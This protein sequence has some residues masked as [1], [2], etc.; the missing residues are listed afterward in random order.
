MYIA[1][2]LSVEFVYFHHTIMVRAA[3]QTRHYRLYIRGGVSAQPLS[4]RILDTIYKCFKPHMLHTLT[5]YIAGF[6]VLSSHTDCYHHSY[7]YYHSCLHTPLL[8]LA[9]L[10]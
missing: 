8:L 7:Y 5:N 4:R 2:H 6:G 3:R 10:L 9:T 1:H